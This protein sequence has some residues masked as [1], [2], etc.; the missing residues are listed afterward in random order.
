MFFHTWT[1]GLFFLVVFSVYL[2]VRS[3][4][5]ARELCL[6][7]ASWT[8]YAWWNPLYLALVIGSTLVDWYAVLRMDRSG[9]RRRDR[10]S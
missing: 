6:L 2:C 5:G 3:R 8:F 1:F 10:K 4:P 9:R 7:C